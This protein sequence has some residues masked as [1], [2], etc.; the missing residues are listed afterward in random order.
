MQIEIDY[1]NTGDSRI[2]KEDIGPERF[3]VLPLELQ[4]RILFLLEELK[5]KGVKEINVKENIPDSLFKVGRYWVAIKG[6]LD[7]EIKRLFLETIEL[8]IWYLN[9]HWSRPS[10]LKH[11][12]TFFCADCTT[13]S[14]S[15]G[16]PE[17]CW[18]RSCTSHKRWRQVIGD[19]YTTP[20]PP[21]VELKKAS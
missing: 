11:S 13:M 9:P 10:D 21:P 4:K 2:I 17:R 12:S 7:Q 20:P 5:Q 14:R 18:V 15:V 8:L 16:Q 3:E 6:F 1:Q 19:S